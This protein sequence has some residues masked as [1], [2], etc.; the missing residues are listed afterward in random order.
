MSNQITLKGTLLFNQSNA[1]AATV[2]AWEANNSASIGECTV[3]AE[4]NGR[5]TLTATPAST[6]AVLYIT[7]ELQDTHVVL[8]SVL[9]P[10]WQEE[11]ATKGVVVNELTT[12][13]SAFTCAQFFNGLQLSG[14]QK[15]VTIAAKNT[16]NLVNPVTGSWGDVLVDPFNITQNETLARLNT[17]AALITACG[18]VNTAANWQNELLTYAT[19]VGGNAPENTAEAMIGIAQSRSEE[20]RVGR[21]GRYG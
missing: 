12:V 14:N 5:F 16:P 13:A 8:L 4:A 9:S 7:A 2:K 20:R 19:P 17:L 15:G 1:V 6:T 11:I 21:E 3:T 18:T 10:N